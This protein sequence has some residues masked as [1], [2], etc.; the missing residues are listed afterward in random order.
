MKFLSSHCWDPKEFIRSQEHP[1]IPL[2]KRVF[3]IAWSKTM[4]MCKQMCLID[5]IFNKFRGKTNI[6]FIDLS[7]T[8]SD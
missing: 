5:I 6:K 4:W 8:G 7:N 2:G 1:V 3:S